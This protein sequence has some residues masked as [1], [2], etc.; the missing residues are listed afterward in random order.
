L[1]SGAFSREKTEGLEVSAEV[2]LEN[3]QEKF[4]VRLYLG[5][6]P[7]ASKSRRKKEDDGRIHFPSKSLSMA[8]FFKNWETLRRGRNPLFL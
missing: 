5:T 4:R 8:R 1:A 3:F 2:S 6:F 7:W